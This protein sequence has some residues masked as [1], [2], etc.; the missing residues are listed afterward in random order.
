M[1]GRSR[2]AKANITYLALDQLAGLEDTSRT[3][4]P[5]SRWRFPLERDESV[6]TG[7]QANDTAPE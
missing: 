6:E 3:N 1:V 2:A 5:T 4:R 7:E